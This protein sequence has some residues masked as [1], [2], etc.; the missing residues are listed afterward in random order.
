M[1][2]FGAI[3]ID[4]FA[5][6]VP[7]LDVSDL[8]A[9]LRFWCGLLGFR[10]AYARSVEGFT[11][12]ER[13]GAQIM[14]QRKGGGWRTAELERPFGRGLNFQILV[15]RQ[16]PILARIEA[17]GWPLFRPLETAWYRAGDV[18]VGLVQWLVQDPD[19][20]LVRIAERIGTRTLSP[21]GPA[22]SP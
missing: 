8:D 12:L 16:A 11:Y 15:D 1:S 20:Y 19:G 21:V 18:E 4:G 3:P 9:S 13:D 5:A 10:V 2:A 17:A 14:L 7:E 22:S 6:L